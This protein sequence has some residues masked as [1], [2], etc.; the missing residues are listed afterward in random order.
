[1]LLAG[2]QIVCHTKHVH[3]TGSYY[4]FGK[5]S[6]ADKDTVVRPIG[7]IDILISLGIGKVRHLYYNRPNNCYMLLL[8]SYFAFPGDIIQARWVNLYFLV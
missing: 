8:K 1:M 7:D 2:R 3:Q 4:N 6:I 5:L